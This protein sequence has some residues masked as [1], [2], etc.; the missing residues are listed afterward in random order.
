MQ[1][2]FDFMARYGTEA[3]CVERLAD[4]RWPGG[5]VCANCGGRETWHLKAR[6]RTFEC[7]G[8]GHQESIT[9]GLPRA[10][11]AQLGAF[12]HANVERKSHLL[13]DGFSSYTGSGA[14]LKKHFKHTPIVQG[15]GPNAANSW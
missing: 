12:L 2:L 1:G 9:A 4:L 5:Y 6:P 3:Q 7:R 8:C 11:G 10:T 15:G 13:T 14:A